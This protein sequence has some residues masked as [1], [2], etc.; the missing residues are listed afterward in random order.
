MRTLEQEVRWE[1]GSTGRRLSCESLPPGRECRGNLAVPRPCSSPIPGFQPPAEGWQGPPPPGLPPSSGWACPP[2]ATLLPVLP[3]PSAFPDPQGLQSRGLSLAMRPSCCGFPSLRTPWPC[4]CSPFSH[5]ALP[6]SSSGSLGTPSPFMVTNGAP[7]GPPWAVWPLW[8]PGPAAV[9]GQG[10]VD[11]VQE[12]VQEVLGCAEVAESVEELLHV[13]LQEGVAGVERGG[14]VTGPAAARPPALPTRGQA[15]GSWV[16][17]VHASS[18]S[19]H[20]TFPVPQESWGGPA[21]CSLH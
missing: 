15:P 10:A 17:P 8:G 21:P 2:P 11:A 19:P 3:L 4:P 9:P 7:R 14:Q 1:L 18:Q 5:P 20:Q 6:P 12:E 13:A 16:L